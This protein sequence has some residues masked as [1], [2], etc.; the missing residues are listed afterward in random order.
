MS[1]RRFPPPWSL[2][3]MGHCWTVKDAEGK[4]LVNVPYDERVVGMTSLGLT[5]R[6]AWKIAV[7]VA[8][9][10]ELLGRKG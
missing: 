2:E 6:E 9:L 1:E 4:C 7:N 10:P 8:K 3:D 5:K